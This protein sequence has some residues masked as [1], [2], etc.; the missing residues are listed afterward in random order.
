MQMR[1]TSFR[2]HLGSHQSLIKINEGKVNNINIHPLVQDPKKKKKKKFFS[3]DSNNHHRFNS[4]NTVVEFSVFS[5]NMEK[6]Q[7]ER[8]RVH[9]AGSFPYCA[10]GNLLKT[11]YYV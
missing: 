11:G 2:E 6:R 10:I 1:A 7:A 9:C 8:K 5:S 3:H 4:H